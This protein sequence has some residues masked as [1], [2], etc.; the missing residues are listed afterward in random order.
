MTSKY[1]CIKLTYSPVFYNKRARITTNKFLKHLKKRNYANAFESLLTALVD[2][3]DKIK[4]I[5]VSK[6]SFIF[7]IKAGSKTKKN[8]I[9]KKLS[10][11][12]S[13]YADTSLESPGFEIED[14]NGEGI[15]YPRIVQKSIKIY[16]INKHKFQTTSAIVSKTV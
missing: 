1:F 9:L 10:G 2:I 16:E 14:E 7:Q 8:E 3:C 12:E 5:K 13:L 4:L 15:G 6:T 11:V